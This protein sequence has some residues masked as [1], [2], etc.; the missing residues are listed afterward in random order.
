MTVA[1][2]DYAGFVTCLV[3][4]RLMQ[5]ILLQPQSESADEET[6][7]I[8]TKLLVTIVFRAN[9]ERYLIGENNQSTDV[10][11]H[12]ASLFKRLGL[13]LQTEKAKV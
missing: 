6:I 5:Q 4:S 8:S 9:N 10:D 13:E 12:T 11:P 1:D 2:A 3:K 7:R